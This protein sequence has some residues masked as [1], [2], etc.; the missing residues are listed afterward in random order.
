VDIQSGTHTRL[1]N[2]TPILR[3][4]WLATILFAVVLS[5]RTAYR[6]SL[7]TD[8]YAFA[9]DPFGYLLMAKEI[10][11]SFNA[12]K[13]PDFR[14]ESAQTRTLIEFM[15]SKNVPVAQW[16]EIVAPHAHHYFPRSDHVGVQYPP[17]T[18]LTLAAFHQGTAIYRLNQ[19]TV[20]ILLVIGVLA[21]GFA[22]WKKAWVTAGLLAVAFHVAFSVLTRI[23]TLSFSINAILVPMLLT[24]LLALAAWWLQTTRPRLAWFAALGAG[25]LLG[26]ATLIRLPTLLV[27]P[28]FLFLLWPQSW[29][30]GFKSLP[31][32]FIVAFLLVGV[33]PVLVYQQQIAGAWYL[34]T[35]ASVDAALPNVARVNENL[36]YFFGRGGPA[37][38]DNWAL[39]ATV[40]GMMGFFLLRRDKADT[41]ERSRLWRLLLS[42]LLVWV[43][44]AVFFVTHWVTGPH[45]MIP[46]IFAAVTLVAFGALLIESRTATR[47]DVRRAT[48][49]IALA[50]VL[51]TGLIVVY[52]ACSSRSTTPAPSQPIAHGPLK[53]TSELLDEHAWIWA[54]LTTGTLWYYDGKPAFKIQFTDPQTR[55]LL[56]KFVF[57]RGERQY[58]IQDSEEMQRFMKEIQQL[59]GTLELRGKLDHHPYFLVHWPDTGPVAGNHGASSTTN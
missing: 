50:C 35:Y 9:C 53:L 5:A 23:N 24:C 14:I 55:A 58:L 46:S 20:G 15:K 7:R 3:Y 31:L 17:G 26:F 33:L 19:A 18:A 8:E 16:E 49:W 45:Y 59:G 52:R 21:I 37:A 51:F 12:G 47:V 38:K 2:L 41:E 43:L 42:A 40:I 28:A 34:S 1:R 25:I 22:A 44:S 11:E 4:F 39:G 32:I 27:A 13:R 48:H 56:Y 57:D 10:R 29:R 54:D 30:I 36:P 6:E